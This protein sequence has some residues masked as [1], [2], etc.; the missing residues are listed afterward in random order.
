MGIRIK[1]E[2]IGVRDFSLTPILNFEGE[3][4]WLEPVPFILLHLLPFLAGH[5]I[6]NIIVI[7]KKTCRVLI[8]AVM[9]I[10]IKGELTGV[11]N[12]FLTPV[13]NF[14]GERPW[15]EPVPHYSYYKT[16]PQVDFVITNLWFALFIF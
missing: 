10:R 11:R 8:V 12:L 16:N 13:L 5:N 9:G 15:L 6:K 3:R 4:P 2:V 1:G 14:E 7:T